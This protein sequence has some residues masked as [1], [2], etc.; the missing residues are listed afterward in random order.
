M[1]IKYTH[2]YTYS[3]KEITIEQLFIIASN[4]LKKLQ[5]GC[6]TEFFVVLLSLM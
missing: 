5:I 2:T 4:R 1:G 3:I 6:D